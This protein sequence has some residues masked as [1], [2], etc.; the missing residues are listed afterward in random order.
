MELP[1]FHMP[2]PN[3]VLIHMWERGWLYLKKAGT[4]ILG[5]SILLW[6]IA[7]YPKKSTFDRDYEGELKRIEQRLI[8]ESGPDAQSMFA[9]EQSEIMRARKSEELAYSLAGRI[10]HAI[11]PLLKP[12]GF[13]WKIGTALIGAFAAKEVFVAQMGIVYSVG[14]ADEESNALRN[15][16]RSHYSPLIAFCIMLFCLIGTPCMATIAITRRES[17]SWKWALM[18]FGGLTTL[19]YLLTALAF[20]TGRLFGIGI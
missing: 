9:D 4:V 6:V 20:Q 7:S 17:N 16:L 10:G 18:Q 2:T 5:I 3:G 13:D 15:R 19:A 1:P 14:D 12:M 11:E 8:P